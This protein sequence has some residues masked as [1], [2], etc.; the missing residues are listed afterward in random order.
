MDFQQLKEVLEPYAELESP[1]FI[2]GM[3]MGLISVDNDIQ[4]AVWLKKIIEEAQIKKVKESF[5]KGLHEMFLETNKG[6][7][8]SGFELKLCLP[9]DN[10][11]AVIR[12]AMLGQMCEGII[13]GIGLGGGL[14]EAEQEISEEIRELVNDLGEISRIDF[15][16][17]QDLEG[18][19]EQVAND[20]TQLEEF[21]KVGVLMLNEEL[22]PTQAAPIMNP[23][24][25]TLSSQT[26]SGKTLH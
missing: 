24:D 12:A 18:D 3:L 1:A 19:E 15:I 11:S 7:N 14:S 8:G 25:E 9:D 4:E 22:S 5:L 23:D 21:I 20:L 17:L 16:S 10:E 2:Q 6:M 26:A 13:Y